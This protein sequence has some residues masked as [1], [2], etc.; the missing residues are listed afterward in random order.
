MKKEIQDI[1]SYKKHRPWEMPN[2]HWFWYQEWNDVLFLHYQIQ[3][4]DLRK[5]VP[6]F[7]ELDSFEGSYFVSVVAFTMNQIYIRNTFPIGYFSNFHEVNLRTYVKNKNKPGVYFLSIEAEKLIPT[8]MAKLLSGLPYEH[9]NIVRSPNFYYMN[10]KRSQIKIDFTVGNKNENLKG[11]DLWLTERYCLYKDNSKNQIPLEVHHK[12]WDLYHCE[13]K[14][15]EIKYQKFN[16]Y[17]DFNHP[18]LYHYSPGVKVIAW[19]QN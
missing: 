15:L 5:L 16:E 2:R 4:K 7:L 17:L 9:S 6:D 1:I 13:L 3:E 14:N 10:G 19:N 11:I 12:P 8:V 18:S